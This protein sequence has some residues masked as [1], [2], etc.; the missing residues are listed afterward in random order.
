MISFEN[1]VEI[2]R[3]VNEVFDFIA[4]FAN[5]PKWNYY[6]MDV[7]QV[8]GKDP[9]AGAVYHQTR[10]HDEQTY[11]VTDYQSDRQV[12]VETVEGSKPAFERRLTFEPTETGTQVIDRWNLELH[13]NPLFERLGRGHV[14]SAV[15][16][17]LGKLKQLLEKRETRLQDG[18][19]MKL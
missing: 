4:D 15:A 9:G 10:L 3:P 13:V 16:E 7:R 19:V 18:R 17:N 11:R 5:T 8:A 14:Q 6:V 12:V 1:T 2:Q